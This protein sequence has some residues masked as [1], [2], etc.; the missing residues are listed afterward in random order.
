MASKF[1]GA[2]RT[3]RQKARS[4]TPNMPRPQ[5]RLCWASSFRK[6]QTLVLLPLEVRTRTACLRKL[7]SRS[8]MMRARQGSSGLGPFGPSLQLPVQ[9]EKLAA[10]GVLMYPG[11]LSLPRLEPT[12]K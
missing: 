5:R 3:S 4:W 1:G 2:C 7:R 6:L 9:V 11:N 10:E 12:N 8:S